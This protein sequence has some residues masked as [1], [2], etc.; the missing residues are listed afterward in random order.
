M[1]RE[2]VAIIELIKILINAGLVW[3]VVMGIYPLTDVQQAATLAFVMAVV[4]VAGAFWQRSLVSSPA[5]VAKLLNG[6]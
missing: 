5:T 6:K 2:P 4:N 1:D 3:V